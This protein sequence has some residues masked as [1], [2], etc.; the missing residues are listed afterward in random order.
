MEFA[1]DVALAQQMRIEGCGLVIVWMSEQVSEHKSICFVYM[2]GVH[3]VICMHW[4]GFEVL[5]AD[6]CVAV[7]EF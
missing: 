2:F 6:L 5:I 3:D 4:V 7:Y 1:A